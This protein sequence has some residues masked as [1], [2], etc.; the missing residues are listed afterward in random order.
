MEP[1]KR[2]KFSEEINWL[3][4][5]EFIKPVEYPKWVSNIVIVPKE[6]GNIWVCSDFTNLKKACLMYPYPLPHIND[7]FDATTSF[8]WLSFLDAFSCYNQIPLYEPA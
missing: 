4:L 7:F 1:D 6:I 8:K 5:V 2:V 3:L